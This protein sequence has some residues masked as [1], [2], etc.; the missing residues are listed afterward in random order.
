MD[1]AVNGS[2]TGVGLYRD[3]EDKDMFKSSRFRGLGWNVCMKPWVWFLVPCTCAQ[4]HTHTHT[5]SG[6]NGDVELHYRQ[7]QA[8]SYRAG[9]FSCI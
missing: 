6:R 4:M 7:P 1:T 9:I 2:G 5:G 8:P 3:E